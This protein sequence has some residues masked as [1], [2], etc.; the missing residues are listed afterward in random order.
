MNMVDFETLKNNAYWLEKKGLFRRAIRA[1][2]TIATTQRFEDWQ[3]N[4]AWSSL[5]RLSYFPEK[6]RQQSPLPQKPLERHKY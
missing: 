6:D 5:R 1:W 2:Q 3:R 4:I